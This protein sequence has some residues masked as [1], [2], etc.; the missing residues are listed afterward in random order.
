MM[1]EL[2][3]K[4]RR[5]RTGLL[6]KGLRTLPGATPIVPLIVGR[7]EAAAAMNDYLLRHGVFGAAISFP[8]VPEGEARI[9]FQVSL[10]HSD[11]VLDE[12]VEIISR[13]ALE[14]LH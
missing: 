1:S 7:T 14:M 13:G 12:T 3:G 10:G 4:A 6:K 11:D 2:A 8:A 9:R 5:F